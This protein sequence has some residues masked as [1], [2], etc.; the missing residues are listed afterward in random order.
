MTKQRIFLEEQTSVQVLVGFSKKCS[1]NTCLGYLTDK[2]T[3][4]FENGLFT[5]MILI[6]LLKAFD[7][8]D[9]HILLK[10]IKYHDFFKNT[11]TWFKS[12]SV[13]GNL[14]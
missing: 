10:K 13:N 6:H 3:T 7:T 2:I 8:I 12:I 5:G 14:K 9:H 4:G 1:T 11:F